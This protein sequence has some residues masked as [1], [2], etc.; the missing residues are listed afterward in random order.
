MKLFSSKMLLS[1]ASH[2]ADG[3]GKKKEGKKRKY[4]FPSANVTKP[5]FLEGENTVLN[6]GWSKVLFPPFRSHSLCLT[7]KFYFA[8]CTA[9]LEFLK[10]DLLSLKPLNVRLRSAIV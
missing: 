1:I 4:T 8:I 7:S 5:P 10:G 9:L 6:I 2:E 3:L